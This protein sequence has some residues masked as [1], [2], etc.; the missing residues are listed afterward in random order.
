MGMSM[1]RLGDLKGSLRA[2][3]RACEIEGV[4]ISGPNRSYGLQA[5]VAYGNALGEA[6]RQVVLGKGFTVSST[7]LL[8]IVV[9]LLPTSD[10]RHHL[11]ATIL[12]PRTHDQIEAFRAY[13]NAKLCA[14]T[15]QEKA[16][17]IINAAILYGKRNDLFARGSFR[18][19][20]D[21]AQPT[22]PRPTYSHA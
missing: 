21:S 14:E 7:L 17:A 4:P 2:L 15:D 20:R 12:P 5:W 6:D 22:T 13:D 19:P 10:I 16:Y 11:P 1:R 8:Y 3:H 18:P 9:Q